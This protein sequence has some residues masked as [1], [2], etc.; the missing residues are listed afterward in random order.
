MSLN[1]RAT[2]GRFRLSSG[3]TLYRKLKAY[4]LTEEQLQ[5]HGYPRANPEAPGRAVLYNLPEKKAVVDR[6]FL[7][8]ST[9]MQTQQEFLCRITRVIYFLAFT[10]ICCRC[11]AEYKVNVNGSCVRRE[12]CSYHWGRLRR[13]KGGCLRKESSVINI[14]MGLS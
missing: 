4:L 2:C 8:V 5:E 1:N 10:K 9:V 7:H 12:E 6:E 11:G 14:Y 13:Q 3:A